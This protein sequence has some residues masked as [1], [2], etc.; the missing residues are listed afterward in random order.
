MKEQEFLEKIEKLNLGYNL[1]KGTEGIE[2]PIYFGVDE[3]NNINLDTDGM[4]DEFEQ[5]LND[6]WEL[7]NQ[8]TD[9]LTELVE[10]KIDKEKVK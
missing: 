8:E 2:I 5:K 6:V 7:T 3:N 9:E 10:E 4:K 1:P